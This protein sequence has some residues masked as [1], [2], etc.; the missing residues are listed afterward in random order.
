M[1]WLTLLE[2]PEITR[3]FKWG[4]VL[5]K[6]NH[7][8]NICDFWMCFCFVFIDYTAFGTGVWLYFL[9]KK[10]FRVQK[11]VNCRLWSELE[12]FF[13]NGYLCPYLAKMDL[14]IFPFK[15]LKA[16]WG[17]LGLKFWKIVFFVWG[18][19]EIEIIST[20]FCVQNWSSVQ[21]YK[22]ERQSDV[23]VYM[24]SRA[25]QTSTTCK[26]PKYCQMKWSLAEF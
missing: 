23:H 26:V 16:I 3:G 20:V 15:Y 11:A 9:K 17:C 10:K 6:Y 1:Y 21:A 19:L 22:P 2:K 4:S 13:W 8:S 7:F 25:L 18:N 12:T 5:L 24:Y 14:E